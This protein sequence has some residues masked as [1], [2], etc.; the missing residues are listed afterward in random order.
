MEQVRFHK[1]DRSKKPDGTLQ[2]NQRFA[3][4]IV[5]V[6]FVELCC[7]T[8]WVIFVLQRHIMSFCGLLEALF[9]TCPSVSACVCVYVHACL[10]KAFSDWLAIEF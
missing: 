1:P 2:C 5:H 8:V 7:V 4:V 3:E 9:S 10:A 6:I